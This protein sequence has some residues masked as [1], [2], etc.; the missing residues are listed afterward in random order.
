MDLP[1][2]GA[3][4]AI[5]HTAGAGA[6]GATRP[7]GT[8]A[9]PTSGPRALTS[10]PW[11]WSSRTYLAMQFFFCGVNSRSVGAAGDQIAVRG[12]MGSRSGEFVPDIA[13]GVLGRVPF[14]RRQLALG[15]NSLFMENNPERV[16]EHAHYHR[17][18]I[19]IIR[20]VLELAQRRVYALFRSEVCNLWW[21][22]YRGA[23]DTRFLAETLRTFLNFVD[24]ILWVFTQVT[25]SCQIW[26]GF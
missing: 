23:S 17:D 16:V 25:H 9:G 12:L 26:F 19:T 1:M 24:K 10:V 5:S 3:K 6:A 22:T 15:A 18:E 4:I 7:P 13:A 14:P 21:L 20:E 11:R 2:R 8:A